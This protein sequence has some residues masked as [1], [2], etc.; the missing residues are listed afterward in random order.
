MIDEVNSW[1]ETNINGLIKEVL[2]SGSL[3]HDTVLVLANALYFKGAWYKHFDETKTKIKD[4]H[5]LSGDK[6]QVPFMT[7]MSG[8]KHFYKDCNDYKVLQ[9]PYQNGND[10]RKFSMCFFLPNKTD[11]LKSMLDEF[12]SNAGFYNQEFELEEE[13]LFEFWIPRFKFT[14]EFEASSVI[15]NLGLDRPF[16]DTGELNGMVNSPDCNRL[17]VSRVFHTLFIEVNEEGTE[18]AASTA[19]AIVC[20]SASFPRN[21]FVAD[22][23]FVFMVIEETKLCCSLVLLLIPVERMT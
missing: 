20:K 13:D 22:H 23:P 9:I 18:A 21:R 1:V 12:S 3:E 7:S 15:K 5:R 4:F 14:Y 19:V 10:T 6:L 8:E 17:C 2:P 11:G 16:M